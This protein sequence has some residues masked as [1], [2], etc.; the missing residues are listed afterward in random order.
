MLTLCSKREIWEVKMIMISNSIAIDNEEVKILRFVFLN[1]PAKMH[2]DDK[3]NK[4]SKID[5]NHSQELFLFG[6]NFGL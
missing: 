2:R 3:Y 5:F 4:F 6:S 1:E